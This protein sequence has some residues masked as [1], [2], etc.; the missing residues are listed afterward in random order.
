MSRD[1]L[2]MHMATTGSI[3]DGQRMH[4]SGNSWGFHLVNILVHA[5]VVQLIAILARYE[6]HFGHESTLMAGLYFATHPIHTEAVS[7]GLHDSHDY[8]VHDSSP[9]MIIVG[10]K[11]TFSLIVGIM[12]PASRWRWSCYHL[13]ASCAFYLMIQASVRILIIMRRAA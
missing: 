4:C 10:N 2:N 6:F 9:M 12:T 5:M 11:M 8:D 13:L 1:R 7:D 3:I